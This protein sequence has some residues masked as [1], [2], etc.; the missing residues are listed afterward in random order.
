MFQGTGVKYRNINKVL[1]QFSEKG[2]DGSKHISM[3]A[4][5]WAVPECCSDNSD[6]SMNRMKAESKHGGIKHVFRRNFGL[7]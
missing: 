2:G 3:G 1:L 6:C 4:L 5:N 7:R